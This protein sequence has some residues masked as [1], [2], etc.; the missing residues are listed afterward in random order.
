MLAACTTLPAYTKPDVAVP[1]HYA[2]AVAPGW[3]VAKP[4]DTQTRA[5]WWTVFNDASLSQLEAR[6]DVSKG[7]LFFRYIGE[8]LSG[9]AAQFSGLAHKLP[10]SSE[11]HP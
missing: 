9:Q 8:S 5:P 2:G 10:N 6:I 11:W 7:E 1:T 4:A 3:A